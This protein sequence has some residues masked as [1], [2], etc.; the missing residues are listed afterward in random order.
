MYKKILVAVDEHLNSEVAARYAIHLANACGSRM[1]ICHV[2]EKREPKIA[3]RDAEAAATRLFHQARDMGLMVE[4]ILDSGDPVERIREIVQSEGIE[5]VFVST[6]REDIQKRFYSGT[7]ARR[8]SLG[9]PCSVALVRVVHLGRI[10]PKKILVPLKARTSH[11]AERSFFTAMMAAAFESGLLLFHTTKPMTSFFHGKIHLAPVELEKK[12]PADISHFI[13]LLD[14]YAVS[15]EKRL[16]SG[17]T[18]RSITIEAAAKRF[19]LVIMGASERSLLRSILDGNPVEDL[20]RET[21]CNL[22]ILKARHED[23]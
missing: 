1:Y 13:E 15:H 3:V 18:A 17:N 5:L 16:V 10:H 22:I 9:L 14:G 6:H 19:D 21:P 11:I 8:L 23:K 7:I 2:V 12:L 4:S 20:L